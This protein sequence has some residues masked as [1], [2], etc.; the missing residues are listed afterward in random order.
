MENK[1]DFI[2]LE[3][4]VKDVEK[5]YIIVFK[6]LEEKNIVY[7]LKIFK[8]K[9][10]ELVKDRGNRYPIHLMNY[11]MKDLYTE[12]FN[13]TSIIKKRI[14]P[15]KKIKSQKQ[16]IL[17]KIKRKR[18]KNQKNKLSLISKTFNLSDLN[19]RKSITKKPIVNNNS[20][21]ICNEDINLDTDYIL[22][23]TNLINKNLQYFITL[24]KTKPKLSS[25]YEHCKI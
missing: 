3:N 2:K 22:F 9:S 24:N 6:I 20:C 12:V 1:Y 4:F 13:A 10:N 5:F 21:V 18:N 7:L 8:N 11:F 19:P 25:F 14:N 23:N 16:K 15:K 17:K